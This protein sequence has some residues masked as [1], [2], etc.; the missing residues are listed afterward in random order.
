MDTTILNKPV[1]PAP[2]NEWPILVVSVTPDGQINMQIAQTA[3]LDTATI[4]KAVFEIIRPA[5]D[6]AYKKWQ[7]ERRAKH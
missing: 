7:H 2:P 6:A 1:N 4:A 5:H 3:F